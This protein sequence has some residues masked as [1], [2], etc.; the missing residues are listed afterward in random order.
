MNSRRPL[1][2]LGVG[3]LLFVSPLAAVLPSGCGNYESD[4]VTGGAAGMGGTTGGAGGS[5]G[6]SAA[7][8]GGSAAGTG[9]AGGSAA[10]TGGAGGSAAGTGGAAGSAQAGT[11]TAAGGM[12]SSGGMATSG[13]SGGAGEG[14][15]EASCDEVAPCGGDIVGTWTVVSCP[16]TVSGDVNMMGFGLDCKTAPIT[17]GSLEVTGTVEFLADGSFNDHTVTTGTSMLELPEL[18][19]HVS[20]TVTDCVSLG[21][22]LD[23]LGFKS[24][25]CTDN[26]TS[27]GCTCTTVT[28]QSGGLVFVSPDFSDTGL[29]KT[30]DNKLTTT[31]FGIDTEY[32]YCV[33][34][35]T[36]TM[37]LATVSKTGPVTGP[38][39]LQK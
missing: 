8:T 31:V 14:G 10:G 30:A 33:A 1:L 34:G 21:E 27:G 38:I 37:T 6:G 7:G 3:T 36:L 23:S 16:L 26:A 28:E 15:G 22:S 20:G 32:P 24:G 4:P 9:G 25:V 39:V 19:K 35:N 2:T 12:P 17:S 18:C 5:T 13:T 29:Y 11:G